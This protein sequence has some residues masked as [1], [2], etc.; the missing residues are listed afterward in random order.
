MKNPISRAASALAKKR[1]E[2]TSEEEKERVIKMLVEAK[3]KKRFATK[4]KLEEEKNT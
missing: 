3:A 2:N 1:W 4:E